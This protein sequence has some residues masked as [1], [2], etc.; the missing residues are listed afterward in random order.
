MKNTVVLCVSMDLP[1][2]AA[3]FCTAEGI[4]NVQACSAFRSP[5]FGEQY[6]VLITD[7][8]LRGLLARAVVIIDEKGLIRYA[9]LVPEIT[10][11][12]D[13]EAALNALH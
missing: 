7:G 5:A 2:A 11:E 1:F 9:Q 4:K 6:G 8:P 13:Y 10:V 12:P 3:R